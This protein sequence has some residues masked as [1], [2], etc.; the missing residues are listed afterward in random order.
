VGKRWADVTLFLKDG[1]EIMS[2]PR[3]PKGDRDN[4][5]SAQEFH[6][7][8]ANFTE[9][10]ISKGRAAE[11]ETMALAFDGLDSKGLGRLIDLIAAPL[12]R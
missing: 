12:D 5:M 3:T 2:E 7:K 11:M 4:P 8:Y 10:L 1:R 6:D 9:G